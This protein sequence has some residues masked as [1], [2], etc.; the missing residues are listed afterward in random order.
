[1]THA[2]SESL[3]I[4]ALIRMLERAKQ[5][6]GTGESHRIIEDVQSRLR[7]LQNQ[8]LRGVHRNPPALAI[9]RQETRR[10]H[11]QSQVVGVLSRDAHAVL[12]KHIEDGRRYRHDFE[13][14]TSLLT[15]FDG[16]KNDVLITSP[17][18]FPIWQDF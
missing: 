5:V 2:R 16:Q 18:G 1:V 6:W 14:R 10:K 3:E 17:D 7:G 8:A 9:S 4:G 13:H 12:Y 11:Y 15:L